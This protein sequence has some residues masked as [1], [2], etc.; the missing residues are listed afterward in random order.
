MNEHWRYDGIET[1][2]MRRPTDACQ[3]VPFPLL[4][5]V[6]MSSSRRPLGFWSATA[7]VV[8]S[9]IGSGT[10]LLPAALAPYGA[11]SLVGWGITLCGA[12]LLASR[13]A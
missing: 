5:V 7:L 6:C 3:A 2:I 1:G 13:L 4:L 9:M 8:G 11:A 10:F 12:L